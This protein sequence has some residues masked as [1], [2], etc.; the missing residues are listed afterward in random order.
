MELVK[1]T[2]I[3][4]RLSLF[5]KID[6]EKTTYYWLSLNPNITWSPKGGTASQGLGEIVRDNPEKPWNYDL[7]SRHPNITWS[8]KGLWEIVRDNPEIP[9]DY[10]G[11]CANPIIFD[12][13]NIIIQKCTE[14]MACCKIQESWFECYYDPENA[15]CKNRLHRDFANWNNC[16]K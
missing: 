16:S 13:D 15:I 1:K 3:D 5:S 12:V 10:S 8:P 7:L 6:Q 2:E 9:W 14:Y 11:L 4:K